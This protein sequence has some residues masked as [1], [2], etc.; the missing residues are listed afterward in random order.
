MPGPSK[1]TWLPIA[2]ASAWAIA[3]GIKNR[4]EWKSLGEKRPKGF[5]AALEYA[6][7]NVFY[8]FG[9]WG[10]FLGT[11]RI[12][13]SKREFRSIEKAAQWA[14]ENNIQ[15]STEWK[16]LENQRPSDIPGNP[17]QTYGAEAFKKIGGWGGFLGTHTP[18]PG[19]IEYRNFNECLEWIRSQNINSKIQW[20]N[21]SLD[22]PHDIPSSIDRIY[23]QEFM[24]IG[25]WSGV[26]GIQ[27]ISN[28]SQIE[29]LI[30]LVLDDIFE[31]DASPH[32][33]QSIAGLSN[34]KHQIDIAYEHLNLII[35]FDGYYFH[36]NR[37]SKD[38]S[39]TKDLQS[40]LHKW[41]VVRIREEGLNLLDD[42][43]NVHV[44]RGG[45]HQNVIQ[46]TLLHI[47]K[48]SKNKNIQ[49]PKE[50]EGKI[51]SFI[52]NPDI[53]KYYEI[54]FNFLK[55][56][57]IEEA[58]QWAIENNIQNKSQWRSLKNKRPPHIPCNPEAIYGQKFID[59]GGW[60]GF[61]GVHTRAE[62][63]RSYK[64]SINL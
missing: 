7:G 32:R 27:K 47:L 17:F 57:P 45:L 51:R 52:K 54:L 61:L 3:N 22:K 25:G 62:V 46:M 19:T 60:N 20:D 12:S 59:I 13:P 29:R 28:F 63:T 44:P 42:I 5:P 38:I 55:I 18:R 53:S 30:R 1:K 43:W 21:P 56:S 23:P 40:S 16:K 49:I 39:K 26:F 10:G 58:S 50:D 34:K 24:E 6:Y 8:E 2:E 33:K 14:R 64:K 37:E 15:S 48:L 9:G 11:G 36:Q 41:N 31:I 35:E 4:K